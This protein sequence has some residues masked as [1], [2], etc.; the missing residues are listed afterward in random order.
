MLRKSQR[1]SIAAT[2]PLSLD[3]AKDLVKSRCFGRCMAFGGVCF[4]ARR[5]GS[6]LFARQTH[7]LPLCRVRPIL[8]LRLRASYT[9]WLSTHRSI[10][11]PAGKVQKWRS[12]PMG[13]LACA[14]LGISGL[15]MTS[16]VPAEG[17]HARAGPQFSRSTDTEIRRSPQVATV[18]QESMLPEPM[19]ASRE[20]RMKT[21]L[22]ATY[23]ARLDVWPSTNCIQ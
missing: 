12:V 14:A 18:R 16:H 1:R 21:T 17:R 22:D 7:S 9:D 4:G 5:N 15:A 6:P 13:C 3:F 23:E 10:V 11:L 2:P 8:D 20:S 19:R